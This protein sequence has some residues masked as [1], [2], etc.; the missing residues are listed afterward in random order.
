MNKINAALGVF[1]VVLLGISCSEAFARLIPV[2]KGDTIWK[3]ARQHQVPFGLAVELNKKR[4]KSVHAI[5][6]GE[7]VML[8]DAP[9][10]TLPSAPIPSASSALAPETNVAE[11]RHMESASPDK[12]PGVKASETIAAPPQE[13]SVFLAQIFFHQ[14]SSGAIISIVVLSLLVLTMRLIKPAPRRDFVAYHRE[15]KRYAYVG[16]ASSF[17]TDS[18]NGMALFAIS[19]GKIERFSCG[20]PRR[21]RE[22]YAQL[23]ETERQD[24]QRYMRDHLKISRVTGGCLDYERLKCV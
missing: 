4:F 24:L 20:V 2:V 3:I 22:T 15:H 16:T 1:L 6:P 21:L 13:A 14:S 19:T 23:S 5:Q 7:T 8:P 12:Q 17:Q 11:S 18:I 10:A 9:V